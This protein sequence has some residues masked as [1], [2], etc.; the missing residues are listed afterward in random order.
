[1]ESKDN[2]SISY[3]P[4]EDGKTHLNVY[5]KAETEIGRLISN[6]AYCPIETI[7]GHFNSIE[8]YWSW[9][10]ISEDNPEREKF[11]T[12][13]GI[14]AKKLKETL[15]KAGDPGRFD[16]E[17]SKKIRDAI[18]QKFQTK[19]MRDALEK[20][21]HLLSLP[22][23]HYYYYGDKEASPKI[24]D[25]TEKYPEF[26][27]P[28]REEIALFLKE[29]SNL[30][31][32]TKGVIC[33][34]VNCQ[35]VMGAGLAKEIM[36]RYPIVYEEYCAAFDAF[37]KRD[38]FGNVQLI[39]VE[40]GLFVAN[41]FTQ[42]DYGNASKTGKVYTDA[43][44]LVKAVEAV[45]K[46]AGD[47]PVYIP[48][49]K[50]LEGKKEYGIGC[51]YGGESWDK[52][53]PMFR[54]LKMQNLHLLDTKT[55]EVHDFEF[56]PKIIKRTPFE[57]HSMG[58]VMT[59]KKDGEIRYAGI[60]SRETPEEVLALFSRLAGYLG[61]RG[62]VLRSGGAK[63]A[64]TAFENGCGNGK[65]EIFLPWKMEERTA[66]F[67]GTTPEA[68]ELVK[69]YH[70]NWDS[71]R[72]SVKKLLGRNA[73]QILG[74]DLATPADFVVCYTE[75]GELKGGTS[76]AIKLAMD[77]GIPILNAGNYFDEAGHFDETTFKADFNALYKKIREEKKKRK[78]MEEEVER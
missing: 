8:G 29:K 25:V 47:L 24:I 3:N 11:R 4:L 35:K 34:Q 45:C 57:R 10:S 41:L 15:Y 62:C 72:E 77:N 63:G 13:Y 7:D 70:S 75:G 50:D 40:E 38:L 54:D 9:L 30:F 58:A 36:D 71:Y 69:K 55:G 31:G 20:N 46:D 59:A 1:M 28:V 52:L 21:R 76:T 44:K 2:T 27:E 43:E 18:H 37:D 61:E 51:G 48:H 6:F 53:G 5:S 64:D 39:E 16:A 67:M 19:T 12:L 14:T 23:C 56:E 68:E 78:E 73:F 32:I 42:F 17:F 65:K 22:I 49:T 66:T 60:G 26:I 74:L 33:Q